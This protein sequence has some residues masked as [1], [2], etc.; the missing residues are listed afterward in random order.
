MKYIKLTPLDVSFAVRRQSSEM[1]KE[2][3]TLSTGCVPIAD[4]DLL[5]TALYQG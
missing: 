4:M 5:I 2:K 1:V 3:I